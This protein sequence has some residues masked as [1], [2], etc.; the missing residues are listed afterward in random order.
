VLD[1]EHIDSFEPGLGG[2][3]ADSVGADHGAR[4]GRVVVEVADGEAV[5][6]APAIFK[7]LDLIAS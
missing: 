2:V 5:Q 1:W 7:A 4:G 3:G 6:D